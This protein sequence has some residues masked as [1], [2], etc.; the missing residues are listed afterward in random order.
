VQS[1]SKDMR[2]GH[3]L[4]YQPVSH[5]RISSR[6]RQTSHSRDRDATGVG[7]SQ[8]DPKARGYGVVMGLG[9]SRPLCWPL[10]V[11]GVDSRPNFGLGYETGNHGGHRVVDKITQVPKASLGSLFLQGQGDNRACA[12]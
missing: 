11:A 1:V 7:Y 9:D 12:H 3:V 4:H 2:E 6:R 5:C 8:T 10:G